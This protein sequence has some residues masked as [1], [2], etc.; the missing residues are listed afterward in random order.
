MKSHSPFIK[1]QLSTPFNKHWFSIQNVRHCDKHY[2]YKDDRNIL[3][4]L[5]LLNLHRCTCVKIITKEDIMCLKELWKWSDKSRQEG[6][7]LSPRMMIQ[8]LKKNFQMGWQLRV[9]KDK[10]NLARKIA[11]R[12]VTGSAICCTTRTYRPMKQGV[13]INSTFKTWVDSWL[14]H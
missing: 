13:G 4:A 9:W 14:H 2:R 8:V 11:I 10:Q 12:E 1:C 7:L 6:Y 5:K 3:F